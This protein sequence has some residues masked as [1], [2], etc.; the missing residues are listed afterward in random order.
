MFWCDLVRSSGLQM[1]KMHI[2]DEKSRINGFQQ[3]EDTML[4]PKQ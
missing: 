4:S 3:M 1:L 2:A